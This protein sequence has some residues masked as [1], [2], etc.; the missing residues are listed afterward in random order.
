M[1]TI[2]RANRVYDDEKENGLIVDYGNVYKQLE[3]AYSVYGE[4]KERGNGSGEGENGGGKKPVELLIQLAEELKEAIRQVK[5]YLNELGFNLNELS[6]ADVKPM[7]KLGNI[8][9]AVDCICLN[10]TTRTKFEV[11]AREVFKKYHALYPEEEVKPFL[12]QFN[13]IEAIY[14]QLNQ[15]VREADVTSIIAQLQQVVNES[16]SVNPNK[17]SEPDGV[18]IDLANL[19]L[20]KLRAAFAKT[21]RKNTLVFDLQEAIE[22]KLEQMLKENP[23]R[24][25]FYDR[26]KEIIDEYNKGK[27]LEDTVE[28]F[29]KLAAFTQ[30]L[31]VEDSRAIREQLSEETLA[32]YD[33]LRDG[34]QLD[35]AEIKQVKKVAV[36]TLETLKAEKLKIERW[37]ESRQISSQVR[38]MINDYL[39]NLPM[40]VYSDSDVNEK[41]VSVFQHIYTNYPGGNQSAYTR[42]TA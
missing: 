37:R 34:K 3:K 14:N 10:E 25:E 8:K 38:Q 21:Q 2:A 18:Y 23:L 22:K 11:M 12:R 39:L 5:G 13:A 4:G 41:T 29:N 16:I 7:D 26:Y 40:Q 32:I 6:N 31:T 30:T 17:V 9:R 28:A 35:T 42:A 27:S 36:D 1:Q 33:L 20:D 24:L 15:Q 19:D